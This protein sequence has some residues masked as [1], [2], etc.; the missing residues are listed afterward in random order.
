M[1]IVKSAT[2]CDGPT[3][4][5][6]TDLLDSGDIKLFWKDSNLKTGTI[7]IT[8]AQMPF[9]KSFDIGTTITLKAIPK[10]GFHVNGWSNGKSGAQTG[11]KATKDVI[12]VADMEEG[13]A[14]VVEKI[15]DFG[16]VFVRKASL[17]E[18]E[19]AWLRANVLPKK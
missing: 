6:K 9:S 15:G 4:T 12:M 5:V 10:A 18:D 13:D 8:P 7:D 17:T 14:P 2:A 19:I 1:S 3:I 16:D 11:F